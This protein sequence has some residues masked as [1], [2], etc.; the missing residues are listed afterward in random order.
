MPTSLF[1]RM[2]RLLMLSNRLIK[3]TVDV[4]L[5]ETPFDL[6]F[7]NFIS[8]ALVTEL[9]AE[10]YVYRSKHSFSVCSGLNNV[11]YDSDKLFDLLITYQNERTQKLHFIFLTAFVAENSP[12]DLI[13]GRSSIKKHR[14]ILIPLTTRG[15][16]QKESPLIR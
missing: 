5:R 6:D 15:L 14:L 11:C 7:G 4:L 13:I 10:H 2:L 9:N 16:Y 1:L 3:K 8:Q 12:L